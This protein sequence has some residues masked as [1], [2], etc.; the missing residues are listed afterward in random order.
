MADN[1]ADDSNDAERLRILELLE[2]GKITAPE[3][4]D[5]LAALG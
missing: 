1:T 3:A 5:L 4:S 2:Q